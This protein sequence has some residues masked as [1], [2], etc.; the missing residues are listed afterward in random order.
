MNSEWKEYKIKD[1]AKMNSA[2]IMTKDNYEF[3]NYLDTGNITEGKIE[4]IQKLIKGIDKFPSRAKRK[5]SLGDI[6]YSTVRPNL[7]HYGIV[8]ES[9]PNLIVST[10]FAVLSPNKNKVEPYF[11]YS[12]LSLS[13]IIEY[14]ASV[15]ETST[16]T[17]PSIKP[18][19]IENLSINLPPLPEQKRIAE[20]LSS[21]DDKIELNNKINKNLEE[22]A[23]A[24]F[25]Q[26]FVDFEF[27]DENGNPYKSSG[28]KM[29]QSELGEIPAGWCVKSLNDIADYLNGLALQKFRPTGEEYIPVIK[30]KELKN[31]ISENTEK[32]SPELDKKYIIQDGD[33]LF[34]WSGSLEV[35]IWCGGTGALNQHLFKV[36]SK[37]Y[38]KWFYYLW[39]KFY[40]EKFQRIAASKATTMG[41]IKREDLDKSK[42]LVPTEK[43]LNQ[44][45]EILDPVLENIVCKNIE[46]RLIVKTR[47]ELLPKL[48]SGEITV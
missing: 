43:E 27:P 18:S 10:G 48:M 37:K 38:H 40:L 14:L 15:A 36:T 22:M 44:I 29:I 11:L 6:I 25:K 33:I 5:V 46:N 12:Y 9:V 32:A 7:K 17:Y 42:V 23:Q 4:E 26:W 34:S 41:H 47:D 28:G 13:P 24:I 31:G 2:S 20:I 39:T 3:I 21:L 45:N 16:T 30:I 19:V 8:K 1:I 35:V